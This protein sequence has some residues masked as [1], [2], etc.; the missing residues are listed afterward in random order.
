MTY[1]FWVLLLQALSPHSCIV[2]PFLKLIYHNQRV[3]RLYK[4][5]AH[6][7]IISESITAK[8][9]ALCHVPISDAPALL[10]L[11]MK[12][13]HGLDCVRRGICYV[14]NASLYVRTHPQRVKNAVKTCRDKFQYLH[15][16]MFS[17]GVLLQHNP[18][19]SR[20]SPMVLHKQ[21]RKT[22]LSINCS[23]DS[24]GFRHPHHLGEYP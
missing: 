17:R 21:S 7:K 9:I 24:G 5:A 12:K 14:R 10:P 22:Q 11:A 23:A 16:R 2:T 4:P 8:L 1:D 6:S 20:R 15:C 19:H 13:S 3:S 18:I